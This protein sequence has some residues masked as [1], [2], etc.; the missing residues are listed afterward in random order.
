LTA[1]LKSGRYLIEPVE[2]RK[3]WA[4]QLRRLLRRAIEFVKRNSGRAPRKKPDPIRDKRK[5]FVRGTRDSI[6]DVKRAE[7]NAA[8]ACIICG[9]AIKKGQPIRAIPR[10]KNC[11]EIRR[12]HL[13]TCAPGSANW[14]TFKENGKKAPTKSVQWRQLTFTWKE[15][16]PVQGTRPMAGKKRG[17]KGTD[18]RLVKDKQRQIPLNL[19]PES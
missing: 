8:G 12:Y 15:M 19:T 2:R 16:K 17:G 4:G 5:D 10:D 6:H 7:E 14:K 13:R 11:Q 3:K 9:K 18:N 1:A